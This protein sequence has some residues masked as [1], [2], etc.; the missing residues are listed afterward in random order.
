MSTTEKSK[1]EKEAE[2]LFGPMREAAKE[3]QK[4]VRKYIESISKNT[5]IRFFQKDTKESR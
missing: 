4:S 5:G 1:L 3:E 2:D